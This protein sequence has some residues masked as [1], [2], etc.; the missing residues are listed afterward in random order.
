MITPNRDDIEQIRIKVFFWIV[1]LEDGDPPV[2]SSAADELLAGLQRY[3]SHPCVFYQYQ[4]KSLEHLI[5]QLFG[6]TASGAAK[7]VPSREQ[8]YTVFLQLLDCCR[9]GQM[10]DTR[11]KDN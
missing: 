10:P 7:R 6:Q 5:R 4:L 11:T 3:C 9:I 1:D 2:W 8:F